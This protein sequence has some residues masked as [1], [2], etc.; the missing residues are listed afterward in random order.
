MTGAVFPGQILTAQ[1]L[2]A[3]VGGSASGSGYV[4][5]DVRNFI[6]NAAL[7]NSGVTDVSALIKTAHDAAFAA[8]FRTL[9]F[10][11]GRY[12]AANLDAVG[13][14]IFVGPGVLVNLDVNTGSG[15]R[16]RIIPE[17]TFVGFPSRFDITATHRKRL[18]Q[19]VA[20]ATPTSPAVVVLFG[21]STTDGGSQAADSATPK[22]YLQQMLR[23]AYG[24]QAANI[25]V[26]HRGISGQTWTTGNLPGNQIAGVVA[27]P[28]PWFADL[29]KLWLTYVASVQLP[30]G[31]SA[32]PDL[33]LCNFGMND[34]ASFDYTQLESAVAY[35]LANSTQRFGLPPDLW[36]MTNYNP[37]TMMTGYKERAPQEGRD[38][39]AGFT[40]TYAQKN[41][42]GL[43]DRHRIACMAKD[44]Y[45]PRSS[46]MVAVY[47]ESGTL[48][49]YT[50]PQQT[51]DFGV[52]ITLPAAP[53][54]QFWN[55][56]SLQIPLSKKAGNVLVLDCDG[57]T[58]NLAYTVYRATGDVSTA[59]TVSSFNCTAGGSGLFVN[60]VG[61]Q[62]LI[63]CGPLFNAN[64]IAPDY[65]LPPIFA[66]RH[67]GLFTPTV[68]M[69]GGATTT[70]VTLRARAGIFA[71]TMPI[72]T[73]IE[74]F[75]VAG[76]SSF[77]MGGNGINHMASVGSRLI[78]VPTYES[79]QF[80]S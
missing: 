8:G 39:V 55:L 24:T 28:P 34:Q 31:A 53:L 33:V 18:D 46:E 51:T 50:F 14:V 42:Y 4:P 26:Y 77:P 23:Q 70:G 12:N 58:G 80:R 47:D 19:A 65:W 71:S 35:L 75:S 37:S 43:M 27:S 20:A 1:R 38:F 73:D 29:T 22:F 9:W 62:I 57:A 16:K 59:R 72:I 44:G 68:S 56:G 30:S 66:E 78:D 63:E 67:G 79:V 61:A 69:S 54:T 40:R 7:D 25:L 3:L 76:A 74:Q 17:N 21:D 45:D 52:L 2:L 15:Y 48:L 6:G 49:P 64:E 11:P 13:N 36:F 5:N 10:P 41:G 32:S 60:V